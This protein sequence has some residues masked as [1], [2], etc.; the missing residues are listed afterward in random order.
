M[1]PASTN[2]TANTTVP[3]VIVIHSDK[4][5]YFNHPNEPATIIYSK[6]CLEGSLQ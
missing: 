3:D 1:Y 5:H 2:L 4:Y 6:T